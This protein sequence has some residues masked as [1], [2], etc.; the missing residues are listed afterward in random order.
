MLPTPEISGS[1]DRLAHRLL[2]ALT[3]LC[4]VAGVLL[5]ATV[6]LLIVAAVAA[7]DLIGLGMPWSEEVI[8]LLAIYA[9]G[10]GSISA[11]VRG[12]HLLVDLFSH[13]LS[14]RLLALQYRLTALIS[15]GFFVLAAWGAWIMSGMSANN[16]T[17]SLA[18]SFSYLYYGIFLGFAGMALI[19]A[20]QALRG[21]VAWRPGVYDEES[22]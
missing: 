1:L 21:R 16:R 17:V 2:R 19:A 14:R 18:I 22:D 9:V 10:F 12:E 20:W 4:D 3:L 7:R 11:W 8:S 5:L 13:R 6:L 15:F